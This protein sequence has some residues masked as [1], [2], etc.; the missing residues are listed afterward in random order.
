MRC[1]VVAARV[2][3]VR[4]RSDG[5]VRLAHRSLSVINITIRPFGG[6]GAEYHQPSWVVS[7]ST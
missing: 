4:H 2:S 6:T 3:A 7:T 1:E 5:G